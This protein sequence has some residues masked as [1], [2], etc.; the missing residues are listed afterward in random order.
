MDPFLFTCRGMSPAAAEMAYIGE[1]QQLDGYGVEHYLA[2]V[3]DL[4]RR[5][6][7]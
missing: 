5:I 7:K 3:G 4:F 1:C 2:R 6:F